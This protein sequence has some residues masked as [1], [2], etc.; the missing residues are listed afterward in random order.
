MRSLNLPHSRRRCRMRSTVACMIILLPVVLCASPDE[1]RAQAP[2]YEIACSIEFVSDTSLTPALERAVR[3]AVQRLLQTVLG[4]QADVRFLSQ[5]PAGLA[6]GPLDAAKL[7]SFIEGW[8]SSERLLMLSI[9]RR[10][11]ALVAQAR[12][13][14]P[15]FQ[16][17]GSL[18]EKRTLQREPVPQMAAEAALEAFAPLAAVRGVAGSVVQIQFY[19]GDRLERHRSALGLNEGIGLQ[20]L[21]APLSQSDRERSPG[22]IRRT[23]YDKTFLVLRRWGPEMIEC[24]LVGPDTRLLEDFSSGSVRFL[25][26]PVRNG[27]SARLQVLRKETHHPQEGCEVFV[28]GGQ[29]SLEVS[30]SQGITGQTGTVQFEPVP[31]GV[32]FVSVRYEDLILRAPLLPG[33]S[34]D[35]LVFEL[36]T[37]GRRSDYVRPLKELYQRLNDQILTDKRLIADLNAKA[38][39]RDAAEVRRLVEQASRQHLSLDDVLERVRKIEVRA[40]AD[41]ED[42]SL[43]AAEVRERA[44]DASRP[45]DPIL[46]R[47]TQWAEQLEK[48]NSIRVLKNQV[49][50]L[51]RQMDWTGLVPIYER[52]VQMDPDNSEY[53][54]QLR[55]LQSDLRIKSP[56]HERAR[57]LVDGPMQKM[58]TSELA[59]R[60][61][62]VNQTAEKLLE[63]RDHLTLLRVRRS[64]V[65]WATDM[66]QEVKEL[67]QLEASLDEDRLEELEHRLDEL[68]RLY[69]SLQ[70]LHGRV[71]EFLERLHL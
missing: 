16:V 32:Q 39:A 23:R 8:Q 51:Q 71:T 60:W 3:D 12:E 24:D 33:A 27:K 19:G 38:D 58:S 36:P 48:D 2:A 69:Q 54:T 22:G 1:A 56:E 34:P 64:L 37:R 31:G 65:R 6:A 63:C 50:E 35:P 52:L 47:Y 18:A 43:L 40:Q 15:E 68:N 7:Q 67:R 17:F 66:A 28:A 25:A 29:Y 53:R 49:N 11:N 21:R 13:Y 20:L 44:K 46:T 14:D 42:V 55:R 4:A 9:S 62:E 45:L 30:A 59:E 5:L 41:G 70:K 61:D 10:G 26:R 57:A